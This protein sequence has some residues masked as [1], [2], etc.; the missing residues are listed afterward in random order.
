MV[1]RHE[2][3]MIYA[4]P[5]PKQVPSIP[6]LPAGE[7]LSPKLR[8]ALGEKT[9]LEF[10]DQPLELNWVIDYLSEEHNVEIVLDNFARARPG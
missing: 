8:E 7:Q 5:L 1:I 9:D 3:L 2:V 4:K 10:P 6:I